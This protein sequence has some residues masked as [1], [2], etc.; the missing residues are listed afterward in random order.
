MNINKDR[1]TSK[2][3][4]HFIFST[5]SA[6][7]LSV[8]N[9]YAEPTDTP[10][11]I[12]QLAVNNDPEIKAAYATLK[13]E[14]EKINQ[15]SGALL[16]NLRLIG[17]VATNHEDVDTDGIAA[18]TGES[19][20]GSYDFT[21]ELKQPLYRKDL[22]EEKSVT[23]ANIL[24]AT[25]E[26]KAA[27]QDLI[28]RVL[29][30]FFKSL[31]AYDNKGFSI[32]ERSAIQEQLT[33]TQK[34]YKIGKTTV[35]DYLEAQAAFDLADAQVII[36]Q[37]LLADSLDAIEEITGT[38]PNKLAQL[39]DNFSPITPN[40]L[41]IKYWVEE[42]E[43]NNPTLIAARY[44]V[45]SAKHEVERFK[46]GHHPKLDVVAKYGTQETGGRFGDSNIDS[47][48]LALQLDFPLYSGGQ[49]NSR[50]KESL[51]ELNRTKEEMLR[52]H[53]SVIRETNKAYRNTVTALNRIKALEV[54][55]KSTKTAVKA[56]KS[57]YKA[58]IRTNADLLRAQR[59]L[60]KAKLDFA[61]AKY[62][63]TANYF[64]LK[65]ITGQLTKKDIELINKWFDT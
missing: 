2:K 49:V 6:C 9:A 61:A 10:L 16:P 34:R 57:G 36:A 27:Q 53:R 48:S 46:S 59:E 51:S 3:L 4:S 14:E 50:V 29:D 19:H 35:T 15:S 18:N 31:A 21:L 55:V 42:A 20:Y 7:L 38:P 12:Y 8:T 24:A 30:R 33:Y 63:Y 47:A 65:N 54:A 45:E 5:L 64:Q 41:N 62:Q 11:T 60:Y 22:F 44:E 43:K 40:P 17:E 28:S 56:I 32:A 58:G 13:A 23:E 37:D 26:Y 1:L 52:I 25:A 39:G